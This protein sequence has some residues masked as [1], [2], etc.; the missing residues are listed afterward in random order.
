L[1]RHF[2][3]AW[4]HTVISARSV[5]EELETMGDQVEG[6]WVVPNPQIP[7]TFGILN[8]VFGILLI[9]FSVYNLVMIVVGPK[10]QSAVMSS[11][12]ETQASQKAVRDSKIAELKK[13]EAAAKTK[14]EKEPITEE[15]EA[16]EK[17]GEPDVSAMM[18]P[19]MGLTHNKTYIAY[20]YV[21]SISSIILNVLM[22]IS[23]VGLLRLSQWACTLAL[24]VAWVKIL[25]WILIVIVTLVVIV[26]MTT[27]VTQKMLQEI[28]RQAKAKGGGGGTPFPMASLAQF[29]AIASAVLSV[30]SA[31]VAVIYPSLTLWFLTRPATRA[32]FLVR[33]K[34]AGPPLQFEP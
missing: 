16:L 8:I 28:D 27:E 33:A 30:M 31:L 13:K 23:G 20:T 24:G 7:R 11:M 21:E 34:P 15:R 10:L 17:S 26:P 5:F 4:F 2:R 19:A 14:E 25:R 29:Q 9:L 18:G 22:I 6:K 12:K 32:A 3:P 1:D